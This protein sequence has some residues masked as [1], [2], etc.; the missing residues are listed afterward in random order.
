[1]SL[2]P[3][4]YSLSYSTNFDQIPNLISNVTTSVSARMRQGPNG[5]SIL[6]M[7]FRNEVHV[8]VRWQWLLF[9]CCLS[10]LTVIF[11]LVTVLKTTKDSRCGVSPRYPWKDSSV[12]ILFHGIGFADEPDRQYYAGLEKLYDIDKVATRTAGQLV[13]TDGGWRLVVS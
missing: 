4:N 11:F 3:S 1:M 13:E 2:Q 8:Y 7:A 12:A 5:V 10:V 6:G 9:P